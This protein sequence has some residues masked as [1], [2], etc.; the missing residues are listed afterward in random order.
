MKD[1]TQLLNQWVAGDSSHEDELITTIYPLLKEIAH[2]QL[3]KSSNQGMNTTVAVNELYLKLKKQNRITIQ[4]KNHFLAF[5]SCLIRQI[6]IDDIRSNNAEKR[7]NQFEQIT[8]DNDLLAEN[9]TKNIDWLD[10]EK[11]LQELEKIDPESVKI[12]TYRFFAGLTIP[13]IAE[14]LNTSTA[15]VSRNWSFAKSWLLSRLKD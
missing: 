6:V 5:C 11:R 4:N 9:G 3:Y 10:L 15:T 2:S 14:L 8:L 7:G 13:E 12:I 1:I